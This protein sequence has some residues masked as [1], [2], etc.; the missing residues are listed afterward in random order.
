MHT[1]SPPP[2]TAALVHPRPQ[3]G[4]SPA[5]SLLACLAIVAAAAALGAVGSRDAASLYS[6]LDL[7]AWAP[8]SS[9]FGPVWTALY[10]MMAVAAWLV[11]RAPGSHA[12]AL[13]LF[14]VQLVVNVLWSWFFFAW[15]NGALAAADVVVLLALVAANTVAFWRVRRAAG[16]LFLPYLA[17]VAFAMALTFAVWRGNL[18]VL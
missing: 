13:A 4:L 1:P 14:G 5:L 16:L 6:Q 8:P 10:A 2:A 17:W 3:P 12:P 7:P 18:G 9:V 11:W 15:R